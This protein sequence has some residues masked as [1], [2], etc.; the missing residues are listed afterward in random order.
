MKG[1]LPKCQTCKDGDLYSIKTYY[2]KTVGFRAKVRKCSYCDE[3][4]TSYEFQKERAMELLRYEK[5]YWKTR[6]LL[7]KYC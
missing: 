5:A 1:K 6:K 7:D 4:T 2:S 3:Q